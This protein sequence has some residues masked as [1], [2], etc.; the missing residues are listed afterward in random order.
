MNGQLRTQIT[1]SANNNNRKM[2]EA[3]NSLQF[4]DTGEDP[5]HMTKAQLLLHWA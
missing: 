1:N 5:N 4:T 3:I 2:S